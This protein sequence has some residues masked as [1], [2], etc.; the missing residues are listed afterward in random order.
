MQPTM[1]L[2]GVIRLLTLSY[3]EFFVDQTQICE[4]GVNHTT[5]PT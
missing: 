3:S 4:P 1:L 5:S 2:V